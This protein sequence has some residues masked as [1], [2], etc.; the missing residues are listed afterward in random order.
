[1]SSIPDGLPTHAKRV[2]KSDATHTEIWQW[3]QK[4]YDGSTKTFEKIKRPD[5][6]EVIA[7]VGDKIIIEEQEQPGYDRPFVC[8][9]GGQADHA[10]G[11]A[12]PGGGQAGHASGRAGH[13]GDLLASAQQ[14]LLEETG[15]VSD[16]W[17]PW[18]SVTPSKRHIYSVHYFIARNCRY[19]QPPDPGPG[20]KVTTRLV[21][22]DEF[23]MLSE[24]PD[25]RGGD[26]VNH[27]LRMRLY[28]EE[29]EAFRRRLFKS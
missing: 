16:D 19:A 4:L 6:V 14:E 7:A 8:V 18:F 3:E 9:P 21:P 10:N 23:L 25:F 17:E 26:L 13:G 24:E 27:L 1:M 15:Y 22:F 2:F 29:C 28:P 12:T 11:R 20:E 5:T